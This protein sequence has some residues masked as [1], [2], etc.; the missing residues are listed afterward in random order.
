MLEKKKT[1][2]LG[3]KAARIYL[4]KKGYQILA[5]PW[6]C[7]PFGE[8][9]IVAR[10]GRTLVFVEVKSRATERFGWP[11]ESV[12]AV[13]QHKLANLIDLFFSRHRLPKKNYQCDVIAVEWVGRGQ[14]KI[15]H[16][17]AVEFDI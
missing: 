6:L 1:G 11:E 10:R 3:E 15:S 17:E 2:R 5:A 16:L 13:K 14:A 7:L 12:D 8:I 9:D 4:E